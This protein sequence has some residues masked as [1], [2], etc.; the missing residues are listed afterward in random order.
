MNEIVLSLTISQDI[1]DLLGNRNLTLHHTLREGNQCADFMV[2][3][4]VSS[5]NA[6]IMHSS[7]PADLLPLLK[8]DALGTFFSRP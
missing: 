1:K 4:R 8:I 7:P 3:M 6:F 2:K 5:T